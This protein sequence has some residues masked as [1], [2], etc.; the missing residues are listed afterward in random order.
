[1]LKALLIAEHC[2]PEWVSV[3]LV[4]WSHARAI[5]RQPGIDAHLVTHVRNR[6]A[7]ECA[8][9]REGVDFTAI[10]SEAI[11]RWVWKLAQGLR[12]GAGKGWTT[13]TALN[14]LRYHYFE[15]CL[16]RALGSRIAAGEW[17]IVH[18][19]TP[20]S[21]VIS[22][23]IAAK[24]AKAGV[25]F[26]V[27]P[28]NGG[29]PWPKVFDG[30]RRAEKE[31][32][33]YVRSAHRF[34]PGHRS[35]RRHAAAIICG[36]RDTLAQEPASVRNKVHYIPE[37]GIDPKRFPIVPQTRKP[38]LPLHVA[39]IGRLVPYKGC[40]MLIEAAAPLLRDG[41]L[42]LS[43]IGDGPERG[44][45]EA[46]AAREKLGEN[47]EFAGFVDHDRLQDRLASV[48]LLG[49][50][51]IR[52]FGGGVVLECMAL[53]IVPVVVRYGGPGELV[54]PDTGFAI[55]LGPRERIVRDLR[56]VL[57]RIV[58][59]PAQL[60]ALSRNGQAM[61]TRDFTW[62]AKAQKTIAIYRQV[63]A[64]SPKDIGTLVG[65]TA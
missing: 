49:F 26:I 13:I 11:D 10:D 19:I 15:H 60:A 4:G 33:S 27:G 65:H 43:I 2:N 52:E 25:P 42:K 39:F 18:R 37:N 47:V 64:R 45:L 59:D 50:P 22:S 46:Q 5:A 30:A 7:L 29:V 31:W 55:E 17:D 6:A 62:D 24:C 20:L 36:S 63:C 58:K 41:S 35:M 48:D 32:L 38:S 1:M 61:V 16:W 9:L 34:M 3:P 56:A 53:G 23:R 54:S 14:S 28:L 8:G 40:D 44:S 21:P 57:E 12:G 51:S